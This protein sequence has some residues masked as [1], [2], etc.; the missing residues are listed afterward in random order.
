MMGKFLK[1]EWIQKELVTLYENSQE[2]DLDNLSE[3]RRMEEENA[4]L[5]YQSMDWNDVSVDEKILPASGNEPELRVFIYKNTK[6]DKKLVPGMLYIHGG[7]Y[8]LGAGKT[9]AFHAAELC[10][11]SGY[12]II[13]PDYRLAPEHPFPAGLED[14][15][16]TWKWMCGQGENLG[17]DVERLVILGPSAGGGLT[18]ALTILLRDRKLRLPVIQFPL[19][20]MLDYRNKT[21]SSKSIQDKKCWCREYNIKAWDY[22][23]K[24][25]DEITSYASPSVAEDFSGLPETITFIGTLDPFRSETMEYI[26]NLSEAN[27]PVEFHI[28]GGCFHGFDVFAPEATI[29]KRAMRN[30]YEALERVWGE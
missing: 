28:F 22:Y 17:I 26:E 16:R 1:K 18:A 20:P 3:Q 8:V 7:G 6:H 29:S 23:L 5:I 30:I 11:K 2:V 12:T 27:V 19:Y 15:C 14:C 24:G 21:K 9:Y 25:A 10:R 4:E 13:A